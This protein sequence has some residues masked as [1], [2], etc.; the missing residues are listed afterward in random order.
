VKERLNFER[1]GVAIA[2]QPETPRETQTAAARWTYWPQLDGLRA[3]AVLSVLAFH[4]DRAR[5]GAGF[6]GVDIFF[7]L[8]G[9]LICAILIADINGDKFSLAKFYQR[10]I[11][12]IAPAQFLVIA[13]TMAGAALLY[14]AQDFASVGANAAA[15]ALAAVNLNLLFHDAY[16]QAATDTRPLLHYW[17]LGVEEQFYLVFPLFLFLAVRFTRRPIVI[18]WMVAA[19]SFAAC[20]AIT[21]SQPVWAFYLLPTRAWELLVGAT[22]ALMRRDGRGLSAAR[23]NLAVWAGLA[24]I[25]L[26][27]LTISDGPDF[28]G[29]IA[30]LPVAATALVL[31]AIDGAKGPIVRLLRHPAAVWVG[32]RSYSLYLWHWP[33]FS[34]VDYSLFAHSGATRLALKLALTA[35]A[36]AAAYQWFER[37]LRAW[38]NRPD[39]RAVAFGALAVAVVTTAAL[40]LHIRASQY[41]N[42]DPGGVSSGGV[43]IN[44]R[45]RGSVVLLGD[46]QGS[47]YAREFASIARKAGFRLNIICVDGRDVLAGE[48]YTLWPS[49][50]NYLAARRPDVIIVAD[51]W[52][53][54]LGPDPPRLREAIAALAPLAGR[55]ILITEPPQAPASA[56]RAAAAAAVSPSLFEAP[57]DRRQRLASTAAVAALAGGNVAVVDPAPALLAASGSLKLIAANGRL[58]Y[59]DPHHLTDTGTALIRPLF[60]QAL[61]TP[62]AQPKSP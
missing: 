50:K 62:N 18:V 57:A 37:P 10:R 38:L 7:T 53:K 58:T 43:T 11:A 12:R 9:F 27:W 31:A 36:A 1:A 40:G 33:I 22:L 34:F 19:V 60:E 42:V 20:V 4:L 51:E 21:P 16:F 30:A 23:A 13:A 25:V 61:A 6:I 26:S 49:V 29:W 35:L 47:M 54:K 46:S 15:A 5:F 3:V 2:E 41:L 14:S 55:M 28:P 39:R 24:L 52:S 8:S 44:P 59:E 45:G 17:S 56:T 32:K 48:P